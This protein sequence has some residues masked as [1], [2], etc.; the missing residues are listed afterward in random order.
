MLTNQNQMLRLLGIFLCLSLLCDVTALAQRRKQKSNDETDKS[1]G[2]FLFDMSLTSR[3]VGAGVEYQRGN[4]K[5]FLWIFGAELFSLRDVREDRIESAFG[6]QGKDYVFGKLNHFFVFTPYVGI[7][8]D[9]FPGGD[10][11]LIDFSVSL[12]V[13]PAIGLLSPYYVEIFERTNSS[14]PFGTRVTRAFEPEFHNYNNIIGRAGLFAEEFSVEAQ[15]GLSVHG[16]VL[17]DLAKSYSYVTGIQLGV[18]ID[19]FPDR[20]PVLAERQ[21]LE[22]NR[23]FVSFALGLVLGNRW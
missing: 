21:G 8:K 18:N 16:H 6:D 5:D 4:K 3:G 7:Q 15:V 17:M 22:N 20:V 19:A 13:G 1:H 10:N 14:T 9:L 11:N 2:A 23:I 12:G